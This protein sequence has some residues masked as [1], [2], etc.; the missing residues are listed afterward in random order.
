VPAG[1]AVLTVSSG[2]GA[3]AE[4]PASFAAGSVVTLLVLDSAEGGLDVR[5]VVDAAGPAV[6][7]TGGVEAGTGSGTTG[8]LPLTGVLVAGLMTGRRGRVLL[9]TTGLAVAAVVATPEAGAGDTGPP[10]VAASEAG[11][12]SAPVRL[13]VPAAGVDAPLAAAGLDPVGALSPPADPAVAGWYTDGPVP[14]ETGPAVITGHVDWAGAPGVFSRIAE[15]GPGAEVLVVR[16]D[17]TT[18]RFAVTRVLSRPKSDFPTAEVYAPTTAAELRLITCGGIF[19]RTR[20]SYED[21][22]VVFARQV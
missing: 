14:G 3:A 11:R 5:P 4:V 17:R 18:A 21:N 9:A 6:V 10:V 19:D 8:V 1:P 20:D 22:V 13:V 12:P 7:P 16:A 15:L 2:A